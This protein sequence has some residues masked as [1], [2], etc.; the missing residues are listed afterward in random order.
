M[1]SSGTFAGLQ[2]V[3]SETRCLP[4]MVVDNKSLDPEAIVSYAQTNFDKGAN[5]TLAHNK[6]SHDVPIAALSNHSY[7]RFKPDVRLPEAE[8]RSRLVNVLFSD[9]EIPRTDTHP[10]L[11]SGR[12]FAVSF[13]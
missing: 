11:V 13:V 12:S 10:V 8:T 9:H 3:T 1:F 7:F 2:Q 5:H 4:F 6:R